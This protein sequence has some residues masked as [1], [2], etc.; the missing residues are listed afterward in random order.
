MNTIDGLKQ[1]ITVDVKWV[2]ENY[3]IKPSLQSN[4]RKNGIL[5][6]SIVKGTTKIL[7]KKIDVENIITSK[8]VQEY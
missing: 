4:L 3:M 7:Y 6:F 2:T 1:P 5:P 8:E